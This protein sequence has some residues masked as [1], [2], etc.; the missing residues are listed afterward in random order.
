M[1]SIGFKYSPAIQDL[2][3]GQVESA[4]E[5]YETV[6][7]VQNE[8]AVPARDEEPND[9][10]YPKL[11]EMIENCEWQ[12]VF[13]QI[14]AHP[15]TA[16]LDLN[17]NLVLHEFCKKQPQLEI[18][19][20]VMAA[21]E[22]AV[23]TRGKSGLLPLHFAC[24]FGAS[25]DAVK[26]LLDAYPEAVRLPD[27]SD[28]MLPLHHACKFG[29]SEDVLMTLMVAYSDATVTCDDFGRFPMDY[30]RSIPQEYA[31]VT[32]IT[33][34][35]RSVW[36]RSAAE[37]LQGRSEIIITEQI[38]T[39]KATYEQEKMELLKDFHA[40][41]MNEEAIKKKIKGHNE[42]IAAIRQAH[43][44]QERKFN[45]EL[46][47]QKQR[48]VQA[49][50][51]LDS[52]VEEIKSLSASL[53]ESLQKNKSLEEQ[54]H[55]QRKMYGIAIEEIERLKKKVGGVDSLLSSIRHLAD[56]PMN[57]NNRCRDVAP[58]VSLANH[59][60]FPVKMGNN[61]IKG[62]AEFAVPTNKGHITKI[63][64]ETSQ[65]ITKGVVNE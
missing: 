33:C 21:N 9:C 41:E 53:H 20:L 11:L 46:T 42:E 56:T 52:K 49:Q 1:T 48:S 50:L 19:H 28:R 32:A 13:D 15:E 43:E 24:A 8:E 17:G 35:E 47:I 45:C 12:T 62:E 36:L 34:L 51:L 31:R 2:T 18:L 59:N 44:A 54:V 63:V 57:A 40:R 55:R 3:F 29:T 38:G 5:G 61:L 37:F 27:E 22:S 58:G 30:A 60:G 23:K 39:I 14:K 10:A 6:L 4:E 7:F 16:S 25:A 26:L 64:N 65:I